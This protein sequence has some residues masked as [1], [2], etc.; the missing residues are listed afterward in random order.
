MTEYTLIGKTK[1]VHGIN[2]E[3]RFDVEDYYLEDAFNA[4]IFFLEIRGQKVPY[5][6]ESVLVRGKLLVKF[7]DIDDRE[8]ALEITSC[9]VYMRKSDL[10][11]E[12]EKG[13]K[14]SGLLYDK[15]ISYTVADENKGDI[16]TI[17]RVEEYPQQE[18]A[19][20][21]FDSKEILIP[22]NEALFVKVDN[23][24]KSILLN[25]PEGFLELHL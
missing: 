4:A 15:Y 9:P 7:E 16:G 18:M 19:I 25:L 5:F 17:K 20:V 24:K 21:D 10:I 22:L 11:P 3:L 2:G 6:V 1:K 8:A 12:E 23:T 14:D 13:Q